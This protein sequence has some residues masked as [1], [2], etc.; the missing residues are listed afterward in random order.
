M[1]KPLQA[2]IHYYFVDEAGDGTLFNRKG[3][4]IIGNEGCTYYFMLGLLD[5]PDP[6]QLS[7]DLSTLRQHLLDDPYFRNIPSLQPENNK[8]AIAFHAKD[9]LPEIRREVF[10]LLMGQKGLCFFAV[11]R[12]KFSV[13]AEVKKTE[14]R[15]HPNTLYD[16]LVSRLFK[17]R[18]HQ[19]SRYEITFAKRGSSDRTAALYDALNV[20]RTRFNKKWNITSEAPIHVAAKAA[21]TE[22]G[23]QAADY[24]LWALQRFYERREDRYLN[25]V[26]SICSLVHDVDDRRKEG[27][28]VYYTQKNPLTLDKLQSLR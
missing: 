2:P 3:K 8:T 26:W 9:D 18:L 10:H 12:N 23:L 27:Y 11:V 28:G 21:S 17:E 1:N 5:I 15:Y 13:L 6:L 20:A 25:Y 19:A 22:A 4:V 14:Q 24:L 16:R 7:T